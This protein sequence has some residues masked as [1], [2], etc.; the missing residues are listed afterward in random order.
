MHARA[1]L[2]A[3]A[4]AVA[5]IV[6]LF[7]YMRRFEAE[8]SGGTPVQVVVAVTDIPLGTQ[9]SRSMLGLRVLPS[10]YVEG[11]HVLNEDLESILGVRVAGGLR[12]GESLLWTDLA[13][14][15]DQSRDLSGLIRRGQRAITIRADTSSA[16]AGLVRPGDRVDVLFTFDRGPHEPVTI[17][18]MQSL[19]VLAAGSDTGV[20]TVLTHDARRRA[21]TFSEVTLGASPTQ[22]Q[23][24]A[25]AEERGQLRLILRARE[26][27]LVVDSLPETTMSDIVE[28]ERREQVQRSARRP[29]APVPQPELP[30]RLQR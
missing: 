7:L 12:T 18:L 20:A 23:V 22:A 28:L 5:G 2:A 24:L 6:M 3:A 11:R 25:F 4:V 13:T 14:T 26:D 17:P 16:F 21:R 27:T 8:A 29:A 9:L 1:I 10:A 30:Q 19:I 15:S